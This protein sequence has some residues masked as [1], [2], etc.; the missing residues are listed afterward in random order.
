[1]TVQLCAV[2]Q[3][4]GKAF[5][6]AN[7]QTEAGLWVESLPQFV[8]EAGA[9]DVIALRVLAALS[10]SVTGVPTP[11]PDD[12]GSE[13]PSLAG[14][15]TFSTF[16]KGCMLVTVRAEGDLVTMEPTVNRGGRGGFGFLPN[17]NQTVRRTPAEVAEGLEGAFRLS[18]FAFRLSPLGLKR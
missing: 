4:R 1:V 13:M 11:L 7:A 3:R 15:K 6:T 2:C 9:Y 8:E 10:G 12:M 17:E 5:L 16:M 18:P 14:V